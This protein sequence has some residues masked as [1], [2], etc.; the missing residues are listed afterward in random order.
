MPPLGE[1]VSLRKVSGGSEGYGSEEGLQVIWLT[2][3][4][5]T[6]SKPLKNL[7]KYGQNL[8][9]LDSV[10]E[11]SGLQSW[12]ESSCKP[13]SGPEHHLLLWVGGRHQHSKMITSAHDPAICWHG[14]TLCELIIKIANLIM[15]MVEV[16][17]SVPHQVWHGL[18]CVRVHLPT[19][20][21]PR[22]LS[23]CWSSAWGHLLHHRCRRQP[24]LLIL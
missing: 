8:H 21:R 3:K 19:I 2:P 1:E 24:W 13:T 14:F 10:Q 22:L 5:L 7:C 9:I 15:T 17:I 11:C 20:W 12:G 4:S 23:C 18:H 6:I 16:V